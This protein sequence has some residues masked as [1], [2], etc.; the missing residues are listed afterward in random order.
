MH[1][2]VVTPSKKPLISPL[3]V[4]VVG[5]LAISTGSLFIRYAQTEVPSLVIAAYRLI[6]AMC[7][8]A[9][10]G[11]MKN[12]REI[13]ALKRRD[14][15][16][17]L[18]SGA[19]LALH[20][21]TWV[22]SL[23]YTSVASSV[24][25]VNTSPL[26]VALASPFFLKEKISYQ[27]WLGIAAATLGGMI[28]ALSDAC[29]LTPGG[30]SCGGLAAFLSGRA[31]LGNFLALAGAWTLAGYLMIGR[32]LRQALSLTSYIVVVYGFAMLFM[33]GV[34]ASMRL[35]LLGYSPNAYLWL[36][37]LA[38]FPQLV[39]H[40]STNYALG[41]IP[42][43]LVSVILLGEPIGA[44]ILASLLLHET[45]TALQIIGGILTLVGIYLV[46]REV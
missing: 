12:G 22:S 1:E 46:S 14:W 16:L 6:L 31:F 2:S 15:A 20:F 35:S 7:V 43:A 19:F 36:G 17:G 4:M 8:L 29:S 11:L 45:P 44:T 39:G 26:W 30:I 37:L 25:F 23:R 24:I 40:S 32:G 18:L 42:A 13:G 34:V 10:Y 9:P 33:L 28:V 27:A 41:H 5:V 38:L 3:A 21:A